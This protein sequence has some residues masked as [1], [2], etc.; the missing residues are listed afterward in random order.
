MEKKKG[1]GGLFG[2]GE[3]KE[4]SKPAAAAAVVA[5]SKEEKNM[6]GGLFG[7]G[8]Q[9]AASSLSKGGGVTKGTAKKEIKPA[10]KKSNARNRR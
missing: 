10:F 6:G 1:N 9:K 7:G 4:V 8:K 2:L 5:E 3:K